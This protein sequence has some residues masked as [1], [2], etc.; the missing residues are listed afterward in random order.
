MSSL[1]T[2]L[3]GSAAALALCTLGAP[4]AMADVTVDG[5][6]LP[7]GITAS[8]YDFA[9][10]E[11]YENVVTAVGQTNVGVGYVN[12]I[13]INGAGPS[14]NTYTYGESGIYL[15]F[16]ISGFKVANIVAPTASTAG[17]VDFTGGTITFYADTAP[18]SVTGTVTSVDNAIIAGGPEFLSLTAEPNPNPTDSAYTVIA[19][20]PGGS[21]LTS[22]SNALSSGLFAVTGGGAAGAI[23][24]VSYPNVDS[25]AAIGTSPA[26][27]GAISFTSSDQTACITN[28]FSSTPSA[29]P[30]SGPEAVTG[31]GNAYFNAIP[32]PGSLG[33][34]GTALIGLWAG[35]RRRSRKPA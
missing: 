1:R 5:I 23:D 28:A 10:E 9:A 16:I 4:L 27:Y 26:G 35:A 32:E 13:Q 29:D 22:F 15:N 11:L 7:T 2:K 12:N 30:C 21:T 14:S 20:L 17:S 31:T 34:L 24:P 33:L 6:T 19:T 25:L 18:V 8:G 3:L